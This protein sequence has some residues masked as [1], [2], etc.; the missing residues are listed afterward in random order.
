MYDSQE[1]SSNRMWDMSNRTSMASGDRR[2]FV[3]LFSLYF[4]L[5]TFERESKA[6]EVLL[7][8]SLVTYRL[9]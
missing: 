2:F 5:G 8:V 3:D 9:F 1:V 7:D 4:T 6:F